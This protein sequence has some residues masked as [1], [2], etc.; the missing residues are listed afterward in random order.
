MAI[1]PRHLR[2]WRRSS[3]TRWRSPSCPVRLSVRPG[4]CVCRMQHPTT[5]SPRGSLVSRPSLGSNA[6]SQSWCVR[7]TIYLHNA[8]PTRCIR[9]VAAPR[10]VR[11]RICPQR[12]TASIGQVRGRL[13]R[14]HFRITDRQRV[15][16]RHPG[17]GFGQLK[18]GVD[19]TRCDQP[20]CAHLYLVRGR[21]GREAWTLVGQGARH[22]VADDRI[23][24]EGANAPGIA[25]V[26]VEHHALAAP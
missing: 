18:A 14:S 5:R 4:I 3:S 10:R 26:L 12:M 7:G 2:N 9:S 6:H 16:V 19:S 21:Q 11:H 24:E 20:R 22:R 13:H 15:L 1:I 17:A 8:L 25:I 23:N